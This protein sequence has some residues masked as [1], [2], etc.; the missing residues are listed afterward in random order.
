MFDFI[1]NISSTE[2]ILI[3][4]ILIVI[5]GPRLIKALGRTSGETVKEV[6]KIKKEFTKAIEIDDDNKPSKN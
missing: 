5:F 3:A 4:I 1:K 2:L 6:K